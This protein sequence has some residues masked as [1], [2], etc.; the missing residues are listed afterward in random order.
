MKNITAHQA[1]LLTYPF[2]VVLLAGLLV[3]G[4]RRAFRCLVFRKVVPKCRKITRQ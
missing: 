4:L 2:A 1:F 3:V